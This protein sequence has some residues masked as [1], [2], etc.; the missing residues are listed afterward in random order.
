MTYKCIGQDV[1]E[2]ENSPQ[3]AAGYPRGG[4]ALKIRDFQTSEYL[5]RRS[6]LRGIRPPEIEN[7][8]WF[9][10]VYPIVKTKMSKN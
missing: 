8:R 7:T 1:Q 6:K 9:I 3:Q 2:N 5:L 4:L 10:E